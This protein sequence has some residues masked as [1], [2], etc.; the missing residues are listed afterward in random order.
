MSTAH[1]KL[2]GKGGGGLLKR[3]NEDIRAGA[4]E[5]DSL[6][7]VFVFCWPNKGPWVV[8]LKGQ[9][10]SG[11]TGNSTIPKAITKVLAAF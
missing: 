4:A 6:V 1:Y 3:V 11:K 5:I 10:H 2:W 7:I 8:E 9:H